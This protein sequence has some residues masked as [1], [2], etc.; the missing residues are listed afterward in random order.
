MKPKNLIVFDMDGVIIDVSNSYRDVVRQTTRQFFS[1]AKAAKQLPE[2]LFELSDLAVVKQSGGLNNDWDL[3]V[4]VINLLFTLVDTLKAHESPD[5]WAR[6]R[7][8]MRQCNLSRLADFLASTDN[9]LRSLLTQWG[10]PR[11]SV[12]RRPLS[13][14]CR[15]RQHHQADLSGNLSRPGAF[16]IYLSYGT[17]NSTW[18]RD[19]S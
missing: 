18:G 17:R 12:H 5:P 3:T 16:Q 15:Q 19:T 2:P 8:T 1:P 13:G 14:R 7:Q 4:A 10:K 6:Y 11:A 9:P